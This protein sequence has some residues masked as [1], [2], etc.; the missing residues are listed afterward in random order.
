MQALVSGINADADAR[1]A[2]SRRFRRCSATQRLREICDAG[3]RTAGSGHRGRRSATR[4]RPRSANSPASH[5]ETYR[6]RRRRRRGPRCRGTGPRSRARK[7][8]ATRSAARR[9]SRRSCGRTFPSHT[10]QIF[11]AAVGIASRRAEGDAGRAEPPAPAAVRRRRRGQAVERRRRSLFD[12]DGEIRRGRPT[13]VA[14]G[15]RRPHRSGP[16]R[17]RRVASRPRRAAT[18]RPP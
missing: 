18:A 9:A 2:G 7:T 4:R 11:A 6:P 1:A 3:R 8:R 12:E 17:W 5:R 10:S 16:S 13:P 15:R 14:A